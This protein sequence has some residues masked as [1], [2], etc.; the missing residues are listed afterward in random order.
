MEHHGKDEQDAGIPIPEMAL[1]LEYLGDRV[2][3]WMVFTSN[4]DCFFDAVRASSAG[5][6]C[7]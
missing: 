7:F 1:D 5:R 4:W 3:R 2:A 6:V